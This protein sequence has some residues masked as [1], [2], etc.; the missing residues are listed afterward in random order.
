MSSGG[1]TATRTS[2]P[3]MIAMSSTASTFDG[4]AMAISRV[5]L[6]VNATGT[7]W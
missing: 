5:R 3:V 6:S 4:S 2:Y 7:A 1:A